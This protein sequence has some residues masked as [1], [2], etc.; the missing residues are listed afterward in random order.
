MASSTART[1]QTAPTADPLGYFGNFGGSFIPEI[2]NAT[3]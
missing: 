1:T 3:F 2:L